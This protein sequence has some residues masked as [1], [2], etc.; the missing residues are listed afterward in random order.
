MA[1]DSEGNRLII[2]S[3]R[4]PVSVK[5]LG[6]GKY[7]LKASSGGLVSALQG[8]A[9][10]GHAFT[11]YGWPGAEIADDSASRLSDALLKDHKAV[12]VFL[13]RQT[14]EMY[15]NGFSSMLSPIFPS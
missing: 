11:W 10:S 2:A 8:L 14:A 4:L 15:Y 5:D 6:Q 1:V 3:N 9:K 7:D 12:P 13:D